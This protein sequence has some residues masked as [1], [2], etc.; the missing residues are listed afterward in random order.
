MRLRPDPALLSLPGG[1]NTNNALLGVVWVGLFVIL[2]SCYR[3]ENDQSSHDK[4]VCARVMRGNDLR[5]AKLLGAD[6]VFPGSSS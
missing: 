6:P 1:P 5:C 2:A 3:N 4:K